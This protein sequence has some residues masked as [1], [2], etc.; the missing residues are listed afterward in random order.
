M[1]SKGRRSDEIAAA[2]RMAQIGDFEAA[3]RALSA[4]LSTD[5]RNAGLTYNLGLVEENIGHVEAAAALQSRALALDTKLAPAARRLSRLLAGFE[6]AGSPAIELQGLVA[7]LGHSDIDLKPIAKAV[8]VRSLLVDGPLKDALRGFNDGQAPHVAAATVVQQTHDGWTS[9]AILKALTAGVVQE[10]RIERFLTAVRRAMLLEVQL[11]RYDDRALTGLA[12]ALSAAARNGDFAWAETAAESA[13]L[14][15]LE[16]DHARLLDGDITHARKLLVAMLYRP[17]EV[18]LPPVSWPEFGKRLRPK[19]V[20]EAVGARLAPVVEERAIA[21]SLQRL[22][23]LAD[24]TSRE[25]ARQYEGSPYP[26]WA[27]V[28]LRNP[29]QLKPSL[30][31]FFSPAELAFTDAPFDVLI[32]GAGTG[33]QVAFSAALYGPRARVLAI[34]ISAPSLAYAKRMATRLG[35]DNVEFMLADILDLDRL[36]RTF[37]IVECI[38]VLHHMRDPWEGWRTLLRRLSPGGLCFIGLYSAISR[39]NLR[40]LRSDQ[41]YPGPGCSDAAA[42]AFRAD[43]MGRTAGAPGSELLASQNFYNLNEFRDLV[44]HVNE[45]QMTLPEIEHFLADTG[46]RLGGFSL[47]E[48]V[49]ARFRAFAGGAARAGTLADWHRYELENPATFD[50]MY[51]FWCRKPV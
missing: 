35:L 6:L 28:T 20:A 38:G 29:E 24:A 31:R 1:N 44:L 34:D 49:L 3:R 17:L 40:R 2:I 36:G 15:A 43:L 27:T 12:L 33:K 4:L 14:D 22:A 8:L 16:I 41:T 7:A 18:L 46:L 23:P 5:K 21:L 13:A 48:E 26:R 30:G 47:P 32:A 25:V 19:V 45:H 42:R 51:C 37:Q 39:A 11:E 50:A 9:P 10:P